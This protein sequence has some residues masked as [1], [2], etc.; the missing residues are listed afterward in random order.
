MTDDKND[1]T[2]IGNVPPAPGTTGVSAE[3]YKALF[4][5][6]KKMKEKL[7]KENEVLLD[8]NMQ[9]NDLMAVYSDGLNGDD[10]VQTLKRILIEYDDMKTELAASRDSFT[11][12]RIAVKGIDTEDLK[13]E[14]ESKNS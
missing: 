4:I 9:I 8:F 10:I 13:N 1:K 12:G 11:G 6:Y 7:E 2:T 3:S 5:E 14:G